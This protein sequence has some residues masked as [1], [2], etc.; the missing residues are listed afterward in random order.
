MPKGQSSDGSSDENMEIPGCYQQSWNYNCEPPLNLHAKLVRFLPLIR[1]V[2]LND[3]RYCKRISILGSDG[4]AYHFA[5]LQTSDQSI[6]SM[7]IFSFLF[8]M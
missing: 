4:E 2:K 5:V 8:L 3:G 7:V 1:L 6:S